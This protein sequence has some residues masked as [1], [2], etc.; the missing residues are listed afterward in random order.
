MNLKTEYRCSRIL[1]Y[2]LSFLTEKNT[3]MSVAHY[4]VKMFFA[5]RRNKEFQQK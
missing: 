5:T 1:I 4:A 3:Q 2:L